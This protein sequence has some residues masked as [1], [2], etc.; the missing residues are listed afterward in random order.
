M[1]RNP[2]LGSNYDD[3]FCI[4]SHKAIKGSD[5]TNIFSPLRDRSLGEAHLGRQSEAL[6]KGTEGV[7]RVPE[8]SGFQPESPCSPHPPLGGAELQGEPKGSDAC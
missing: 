8:G 4:L 6:W 3:G 2:V 7:P 1:L 5:F